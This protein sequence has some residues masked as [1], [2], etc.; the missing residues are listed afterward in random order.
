[1]AKARIDEMTFGERL[2]YYAT[3]KRITVGTIHQFID[4]DFKRFFVGKLRGR[5]VSRIGD[6]QY[7]FDNKDDAYECAAGFRD[8]SKKLLAETMQALSI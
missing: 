4:G 3:A 5:I 8:N 2:Q 7:K 6:G 1:M